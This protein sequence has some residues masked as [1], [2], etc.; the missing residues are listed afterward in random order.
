MARKAAGIACMTAIRRS[1]SSVSIRYSAS[2]LSSLRYGRRQIGGAELLDHIQPH[3]VVQL[4]Q[5]GRIEAVADGPDQFRALPA[6]ERFQ[7]IG[8]IGI[9]QRRHQRAHA[10][11]SVQVKGGPNLADEVGRQAGDPGIGPVLVVS[12]K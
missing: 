6:V 11:G 4:G 3:A 7:Q 9:A 10:L 12:F 5:D 8:Q 1:S 2:S